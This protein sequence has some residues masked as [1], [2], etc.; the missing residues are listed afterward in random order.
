MV[1]ERDT[2][3][4]TSTTERRRTLRRRQAS[5]S[6]ASPTGPSAGRTKGGIINL[7]PLGLLTAG[8]SPTREVPH[9]VAGLTDLLGADDAGPVAQVAAE[10]IVS[11][12]RSQMSV[13]GLIRV[14]GAIEVRIPDIFLRDWR[15]SPG[16]RPGRGKP[17]SRQLAGLRSGSSVGQAGCPE[18][19]LPGP[20]TPTP[21]SITPT[22]N[23]GLSQIRN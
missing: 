9:R 3:D 21:P 5:P 10:R 19:G 7:E 1:V 13:R 4:A 16:R 17:Q 14:A 20:P 8:T 22:P 6:P 15:P 11:Q 23:S 2:D 18:R 12:S